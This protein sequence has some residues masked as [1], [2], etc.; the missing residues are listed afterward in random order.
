[1]Y[2]RQRRLHVS[3][4]T[5]SL[6]ATL[7]APST[8]A[9]TLSKASAIGSAP[10]MPRYCRCVQWWTAAARSLKGN[11]SATIPS[12][13]AS[14][15]CTISAARLGSVSLRPW[16]VLEWRPLHRAAPA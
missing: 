6:L 5:A 14:R 15:G 9:T 8:T 2:L 3:L 7:A 10:P 11:E 16:S 1:M 12:T 4:S 13:R